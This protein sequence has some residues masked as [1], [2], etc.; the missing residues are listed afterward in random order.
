[1]EQLRAAGVQSSV[2]YPPVHLFSYYRG[3]SLP[4]ADLPVTEFLGERLLSLPMYPGM[5]KE[6]VEWVCISLRR[7]I[8]NAD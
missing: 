8:G 4:H 2:H 3:L 7:A 6:Q 1:M 5:T